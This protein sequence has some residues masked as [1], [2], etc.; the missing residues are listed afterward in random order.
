MLK[1]L[2][3]A[4]AI[5][6]AVVPAPTLAQAGQPAPVEVTVVGTWHFGNP[7]QDLFNVRSASVTTPRRQA[8]LA[9]VGRSLAAFQPTAVAVER[10]AADQTSY[11]DERFTAFTPAALSSSEEERV[12]IGYRVAHQVGLARVYAVDEQAEASVR[13]YFPFSAVGSW[14]ASNGAQAE[15]AALSAGPRAYVEEMNRRQSTDSMAALLAYT[16]GDSPAAGVSGQHSYYGLLAF[17]RGPDQPGAALNAAWYERNARI[18][19]RIVQV[20]RPGDRIV[21]VFGSGHAYWLRH[22]A[23]T[24]PGF[25]YVDPLPYLRAAD[26]AA[27]TQP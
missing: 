11:E 3:V 2:L 10:V 8:E 26:Q 4:L 5:S 17:G 9:A 12:Q 14:A 22:F 27:A 15:L 19:A 7:G 21:V 6:W 23:E 25:R 18:F 1:P 20:A 24:T 13:D 16:N